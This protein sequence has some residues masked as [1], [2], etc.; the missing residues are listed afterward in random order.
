MTGTVSN[1]I[2]TK[3]YGFISGANGQEYFFHMEDV[4][5]D[6]AKICDRFLTDGGGKINVSFEAAKTGKG[7]RAK[8]VVIII[9]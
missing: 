6:W 5:T 9:D 4:P 2:T 8:N 1:L 3:K 7:P